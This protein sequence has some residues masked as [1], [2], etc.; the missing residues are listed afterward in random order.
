MYNKNACTEVKLDITKD[1]LGKKYTWSQAQ[2]R[3]L[4]KVDFEVY[5]RLSRRQALALVD[6]HTQIAGTFLLQA[7]FGCG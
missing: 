4:V 1:R 7:K 3:T 5:A 2:R 6:A